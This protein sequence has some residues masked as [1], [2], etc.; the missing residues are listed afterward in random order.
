[1]TQRSEVT[2]N[3]TMTFDA[4]VERDTTTVPPQRDGEDKNALGEVGSGAAPGPASGATSESSNEGSSQGKKR[5]EGGK[6]REKTCGSLLTTNNFGCVA[7]ELDCA[8]VTGGE[9]AHSRGTK[10]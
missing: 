3:K 6:V 4:A 2:P 5:N 8:V 1:M 10:P 7:D 9:K